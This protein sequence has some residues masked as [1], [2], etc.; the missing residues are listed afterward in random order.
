M[1][2]EPGLRVPLVRLGEGDEDAVRRDD[3]LPGRPPLQNLARL[4]LQ[5]VLEPVDVRDQVALVALIEDAARMVEDL[6]DRDGRFGA[7]EPGQV[8][9]DD[10]VKC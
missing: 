2:F 3:P 1:V 7:D 6:A 5:R 8:S 9:R 10:I 4:P